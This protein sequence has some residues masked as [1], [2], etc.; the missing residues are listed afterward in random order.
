M[1]E[2]QTVFLAL[3]ANLG[4]RRANLAQAVRSIRAAATLVQ[5]ASLYE[6]K[7]VGYLDQPD[8]LNSA[9]QVSTS[10]PPLGLLHFLK[11]IE[12]QIGRQSSFRNAPRPI[13]IDILLYGS[14]VLE[15]D[16]LVIP[17]PRMSDR[18]FVLAPL[19]EIA[20]Q[21]VHPVLHLTIAELL[22]RADTS[23]ILRLDEKL[24]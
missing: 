13:D 14:L 18:A 6:T 20:P 22:Q 15:S 9:C 12:Q 24:V 5:A 16:Q 11:Q 21:L 8:F 1:E 4:D 7:P 10:L 23:G 17:H 3:G 19:A 2:T